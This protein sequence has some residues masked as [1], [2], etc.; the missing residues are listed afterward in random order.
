LD[1]NPEIEEE[2]GFG[3]MEYEHFES[4]DNRYLMTYDDYYGSPAGVEE[5]LLNHPNYIK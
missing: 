4:D 5:I 2:K 1:Q 3:D